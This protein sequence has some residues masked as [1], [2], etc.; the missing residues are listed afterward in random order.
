M[1]P[2]DIKTGKIFKDGDQP[3]R[4]EKYSFSK[5]ARGGATIKVKARNLLT[6]QVLEKSFKGYE[7][8]GYNNNCRYR[9]S[10]DG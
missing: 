4:V 9:S 7:V 6:G 5:V 8:F 1:I 3:F 2:T 10:V